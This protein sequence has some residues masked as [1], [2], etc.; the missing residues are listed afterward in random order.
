MSATFANVR[1]KSARIL[2]YYRRIKTSMSAARRTGFQGRAGS[3]GACLMAEPQAWVSGLPPPPPLRYRR[4][5]CQW[6]PRFPRQPFSGQP[7]QTRPQRSRIGR[8]RDP[9]GWRA[10]WARRAFFFFFFLQ[11][12]ARTGRTTALIV[13]RTQGLAWNGLSAEENC[14]DITRPPRFTTSRPSYKA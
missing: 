8:T 13:H 7:G 11:F 12:V 2:G 10:M 9:E 3:G 14:R 4:T 1:P 6:R 5:P